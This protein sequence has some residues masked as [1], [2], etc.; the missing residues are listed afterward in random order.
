MRPSD[1]KS[2]IKSRIK[3]GIKR[4]LLIES[5]PGTGKTQIAEQAARELGL[6]FKAIHAPLLQPED[7]GF[8]VISADKADVN[9]VVSRDKFPIVGSDTP[10]SGVFLI[11]ELSQADNSAQKILA[12]L[13]QAREIHGQRI[14]DGW[15]MVAT[16]NRTVDRAGAN[17]ILS[18]LG[19][20]VTRIAMDASLDDWTAWALENAVATEVISF[21]R[22]RPELLN[23]FDPQADINP[24]PRAW[25]EGVSAQLGKVDPNLEFEVFKGDVGE[26]PAAEF[27]GFL[28]IYRK[29]PSPDA[30]I[31]N[32]K[33]T[34]V[35]SEPA[36]LYAL[37]G[38]LAAR[39]A[40]DNFGRIMEYV[41]RMPAEFSVL[42]VRDA[43]KRVPAIQE[44]KEFIKWAST[45]G[46][47]LLT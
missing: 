6:G 10:E 13:L 22:F 40:A 17:R 39:T 42:Y 26:G 5:S 11:D 8:P 41:K 18:H 24:T 44:T 31:L 2:L 9:F 46:A 32:P 19:N 4:G 27:K 21:I 16:G 30:I 34:D 47:K 12:N 7:Y 25:V 36:T 28:Q 20:R 37:C 43:I 38:A 29:L 45:D 23:S 33:G 14:K 1:I 35:P 15:F 3:S